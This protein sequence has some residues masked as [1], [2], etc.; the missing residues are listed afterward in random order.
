MNDE[1]K[2]DKLEKL[3]KP[4]KTMLSKR[5]YILIKKHYKPEYIDYI[6]HECTVTP[7]V[8]QGY[9]ND[10]DNSFKIYQENKN[11]LYTKTLG[12]KKMW[13][14]SYKQGIRRN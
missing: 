3:E 5:G 10:E 8:M 7:R 9:G 11:K 2:S 12:F 13:K 4:I 1:E 6:K 14:T